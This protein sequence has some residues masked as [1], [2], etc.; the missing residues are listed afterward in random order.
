MVPCTRAGGEITK[1]TVKAA[2]LKLT[3]TSTMATGKMT[4]LAATVFTRINMAIGLRAT[5]RKTSSMVM[6]TSHGLMVQATKAS[7]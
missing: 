1:P 6:A 3:D 7:T 5:G 2:S 4:R